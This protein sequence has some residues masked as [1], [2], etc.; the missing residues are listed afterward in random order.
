MAL[1]ENHRTALKM[2]ATCI[3][4]ATT[5]TS[6]NN[7]GTSEKS[8]KYGSNRKVC[9][10]AC[11]ILA[12]KLNDGKGTALNYLENLNAT[13]ESSTIEESIMNY[14]ITCAYDGFMS[15]NKKG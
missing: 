8:S 14:P 10:G 1:A 12:A 13:A 6:A 11:L 9:A 7:S 3:A 15:S 5:G 2:E 4:A